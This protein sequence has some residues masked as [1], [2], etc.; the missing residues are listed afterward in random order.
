[1]NRNKNT[2]FTYL[3]EAFYHSWRS[4]CTFFGIL[5]GIWSIIGNLLT[6]EFV[7]YTLSLFLLLVIAYAVY[8]ITQ[9]LIKLK[10]G[11][12]TVSMLDNRQVSLIRNGFPEN[13]S[14]LLQELDAAKLATFAFVMGI[15]RSGDLSVSTRNGIVYWV[16]DFLD[17]HYICEGMLPSHAAQKQLNAYLETHTID[18]AEIN[19]LAYGTCVEIHLELTSADKPD[20]MP[21]NLLFVANSRKEIPGEKCFSEKVN[22]DNKSNIIIPKVFNYLMDTNKYTGAMIGV[23]GTNGMRQKYQIIFSQ[24]INQYARVC[25]IDDL[26][27]LKHLYISIREEDYYQRHGMPLSQLAEYVRHCAVFY[28]KSLSLPKI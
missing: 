6:D 9:W 22:D 1:M 24:I 8:K 10:R 25:Y 13:M 11:R 21:C 28:T 3:K 14:I 16:L 5:L 20:P 18:F 4:I 27:Y 17:K 19:K 23:M 7:W 2:F 26:C 15:D 12:I